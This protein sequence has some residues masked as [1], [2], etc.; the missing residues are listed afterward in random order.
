MDDALVAPTDLRDF[1]ES[2]GWSLREE[3]LPDRIYLF[4]NPAFPRRQLVF[5]MSLATP[6]YSESVSRLIGKLA[7]MLGEQPQALL[8]RARSH[9]GHGAT[10]SAGPV[11]LLSLDM[12]TSIDLGET[13]N[14]FTVK[15][16]CGCRIVYG[17]IPLSDLGMLSHG[18]GPDALVA[19]DIADR[20]GAMLVIGE[21]ENLEKLRRLD[22][23]V[24]EKRQHDSLVAKNR[25]LDAVAAWLLTGERGASS[26]A[27]C[28]RFFGVP[29][30]AGILYPADPGDLR[31]CLLFLDA[32]NSHDKVSLM[33]DASPQW[34][35]LVG[36]WDRIVTTFREETS[37]D[38]KAPETYRLMQDALA[39]ARMVNRST[40][41]GSVM[42]P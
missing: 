35:A 2:L 15:T 28:K 5:P 19:P 13:S 32:T 41:L 22:L 8:E 37:A 23:P 3:G 17:Q 39:T 27:M 34:A 25:G 4:D 31:R 26:N 24:S 36:D 21:P 12:K 33:A 16:M 10:V 14:G 38:K 20:I 7:E 30:D 11:S 6:D 42:R 40:V 18:F 29:N 1:L 9:V